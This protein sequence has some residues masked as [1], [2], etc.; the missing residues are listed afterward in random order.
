[1]VEENGKKLIRFENFETVNGPDVNIYLS[2]DLTNEDFIDLGDIK[3]TRGN[4]S[5][6]I[7]EGVD[8]DK[9][10]KVLVWCVTFKVLFSYADLE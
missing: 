10:N 3:A 5:Y 6:K 9:Y 4:V 7:P 1:M 2:S 8:L